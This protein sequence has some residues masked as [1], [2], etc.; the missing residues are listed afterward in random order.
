MGGAAAESVAKSKGLHGWILPAKFT[1]LRTERP[2]ALVSYHME[3]TG[4]SAVMK[5]LHKHAKEDA[6]PRLTSLFDYAH[7]FCFFG[8]YPDVF[9]GWSRHWEDRCAPGAQPAGSR[10]PWQTSAVAVEFHAYTMRRFWDA[11]V[12]QLPTLRAQYRAL[13]GSFVT[14][15]LVRQPVGH[16]LSTY[17]MWPP[18]RRVGGEKH[19]WPLEQWLNVAAG[20]QAAI[21]CVRIRNRTPFGYHNP[22]GCAAV[23]NESRRRLA[24]T[25]DV[26]GAMACMPAVLRGVAERLGWPHDHRAKERMRTALDQSLHASRPSG[27]RAGGQLWREARDFSEYEGLNATSRKALLAAAACDQPIYEH[28]LLRTAAM[29]G[30]RAA[31]AAGAKGS[32]VRREL[33]ISAPSFVAVPSK[34]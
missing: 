3:K 31:N 9:P 24:D 17:R 1:A 26:V 15:T 5:W 19:V 13:N 28:A 6:S 20:L 25:F 10:P 21:L 14:F 33:G 32:C 8:L 34:T 7:T 16:I 2:V 30:P 18:Q 23:R 22:A 27:V 12:P 29:L 11:L 4:G